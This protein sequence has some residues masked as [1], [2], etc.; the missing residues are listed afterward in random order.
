M[1][2][3]RVGLV[4]AITLAACV[5]TPLFSDRCRGDDKP[6]PP[7]SKMF[8]EKYTDSEEGRPA[9]EEAISLAN[10]I[11][12]RDS[13]FVLQASWAPASAKD[14]MIITDFPGMP[15]F[16][17]VLLEKDKM[18]IP[19]F[20]GVP[21]DDE[22]NSIAFVP[23]LER[24]VIV[25]A[26]E[27]PKVEALMANQGPQAIKQSLVNLL[28]IVLLHEAGHVAL[29]HSGCL[30]G[31]R[32]K[33]VIVNRS[34]EDAKKEME[35]V[36]FSN[37]NKKREL[38]ADAFVAEQF[39]RAIKDTVDM[40]RF[41]KGVI[42]GSVLPVVSFNIAAARIL[43]AFEPEVLSLDN[44]NKVYW[45][46]DEEHPNF[47]YRMVLINSMIASNDAT[48]K[49]VEDYKLRRCMIEAGILPIR[50]KDGDKPGKDDRK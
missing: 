49:L 18:V 48:K 4:K 30:D 22:S 11:L 34:L 50:V 35:R 44:L 42:V 3:I 5:A 29:G 13:P 9:V 16:L 15:D 14:K 46:K 31:S 47:E 26:K 25:G 21:L 38:A 23:D 24:C 1:K 28:V 19:V 7:T 12:G 27:L 20:L 32:D 43:R 10:T 6:K 8:K 37:P 33:Y 17:R 2:S 45:D 39:K 41:S 36:N 40:K